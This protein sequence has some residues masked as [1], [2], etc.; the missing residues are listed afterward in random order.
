MAAYQAL[1]QFIATFLDPK[2]SGFD[3]TEVGGLVQCEDFQGFD[4]DYNNF[5][6]GDISNNTSLDNR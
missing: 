1:G 3:V 5:V 2:K 6:D 4:I